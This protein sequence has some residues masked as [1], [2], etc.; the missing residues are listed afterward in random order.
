[1]HRLPAIR[2]AVAEL[3]SPSLDRGMIE[4][5]FGLS[6]RSA[7]LLMAPLGRAESGKAMLVQRTR[8]LAWLDHLL[9]T[10]PVQGEIARKRELREKLAALEREARPPTTPIAPP[11]VEPGQS[12]PV[13]ITLAA[14]GVLTVRFGS[15]EELLGCVLALAEDA[16]A[17]YA[18]FAARLAAGPLEDSAQLPV[19]GREEPAP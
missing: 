6:R 7:L 19:Q 3:A 16:A 4:E 1:M 8:L 12:W 5:L 18:K 17:N 13:G 11:P 9:A 10:R 2:D 15:P 14:P